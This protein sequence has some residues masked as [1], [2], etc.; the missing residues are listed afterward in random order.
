[1]ENHEAIASQAEELT[2]FESKS[3]DFGGYARAFLALTVRIV[4]AIFGFGSENANLT[5]A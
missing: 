3:A 5:S 4:F 1:M 2:P